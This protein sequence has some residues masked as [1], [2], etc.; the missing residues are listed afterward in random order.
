MSFRVQSVSFKSGFSGFSLTTKP[1][2]K[3]T[4]TPPK[5]PEERKYSTFELVSA[6]VS[7]VALG[8][9]TI[10]VFKGRNMAKT[11]RALS[12]KINELTASLGSSMDKNS[13][14]EEKLNE[15]NK[16]ISDGNK[17]VN[18]CT[19]EL[20]D[21]KKYYDGWLNAHEGKIKDHD[22]RINS[23]LDIEKGSVASSVRN[24]AKIDNFDLFQNLNNDGSRIHLSEE[25]KDYMQTAAS[26]YI[27][28][29]INRMPL[30]KLKRGST[31]W[32]ITAESIPEKEGGLGEVPVQISKNLKDLGVNN[33]LV[34]SLS[35]SPGKSK[36]IEE[37]G[38]FT[39]YYNLDKPKYWK[40]EVNKIAEFKTKAFNNGRY[41]DETVEV[42]TGVDP[43]FGFNRIMF[44]NDKYFTSKGLYTATPEVSETERYA[45]LC[46]VIYEFAKVKTDPNSIT[47]LR[48]LD[49]A[50]FDKVAKPDAFL[51]NDWHA[52]ALAPMLRYKAVC[53]A[54]M[55][56]LSKEAADALSKSNILH[57]E[58]NVDY[59][60]TDWLHSSDIINTCFDKYAYDIYENAKTG[61]GY[62]GI[63]N[64]LATSNQVNLANMG[65]CL[66]HMVKP[67]S[68]T[69]SIELAQQSERSHALQHVSKI[70]LDQGTMVGQSNGW[71]RAV[72]EVSAKRIAKF[73][74]DI[75][76]DKIKI[77]QSEILGIKG[78]PQETN[79]QVRTILTKPLD[80]SSFRVRIEELKQ[81]NSPKVSQKLAQMEKDGALTLREIAPA[82]HL[83]TTESILRARKH[84]KVEF[85]DYLKGITAH[86]RVKKDKMF[87]IAEPELTDLS[88]IKPED[89]DD[90]IFFN[91]GVRFVKQKGVDIACES[92][93]KVLREWKTKYPAR[94][95]PVFV[96]GGA[97]GENGTIKPLA[98]RLKKELG[99]ELSK[100]VVY[101]DGYTPNNIF[102]AC[103]DF[104]LYS[105]WFEPDGAK[106]ESL[107]KGTPV[108][109]T[110]V[111]GHVD[112]V[113]DGI[114]GFLTS[115]T[116]PDIDKA[117]NIKDTSKLYEGRLAEMSNDFTQSI[118]R[119]VDTF[120]DKE[121]YANMVRQAIDG[122]QSWVIRNEKGEIIGGALLGHMRDLGFDFAEFPEI[123]L[124]A[125]A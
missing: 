107:Y 54:E 6:G 125:A 21:V 67:V 58:H 63:T 78:L 109:C 119:A 50:G 51:L 61:F 123:N 24:L 102:Q 68:K 120:Y 32:S 39:Y 106:W 12:S 15:A 80:S 13:K 113:K 105:S 98:Y 71:D 18:E 65:A 93:K 89:L 101:M 124:A 45:F 47:Y 19:D 22:G 3:N 5:K 25:T 111:G 73:N 29:G 84:N 90:T 8:A 34:R 60:G 94:K 10:S 114:N 37:N 53:E 17:K 99:S 64:V 103:S 59:Q 36:L 55:G 11:E 75:N 48:V 91:M 96:I 88:H 118:Y 100:Q 87:P 108:I 83:D 2:V 52:G 69:Y 79:L 4:Q 7:V 74:N 40:M 14:L 49:K 31:V 41:G 92:I 57:I 20:S 76:G 44:K 26:R 115:R 33:P 122:D 16:L 38:K 43:E 46:K 85:L 66:A 56:E 77:L 117:L 42:F 23:A 104:T 116:I 70:R 62:E 97:D 82:T 1:P 27:Y 112:S 72:N 28:N 121:R 81:L 9:A 110:H 95:L 35:L 30:N 86:A